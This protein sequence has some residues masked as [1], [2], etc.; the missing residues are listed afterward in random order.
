MA[1]VIWTDRALADLGGVLAYVYQ[2]NPLAAQRLAI[3][4][5]NA[6][7][8]LSQFPERGR[9]FAP[10]RRELLSVNPYAIRYRVVGDAV[11]IVTIRHGA[12]E[13]G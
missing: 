13:P 3:K 5:V 1:K 4:L 7:E 12:R 9:V 8:S 2:F 11:E 10:G 6:A